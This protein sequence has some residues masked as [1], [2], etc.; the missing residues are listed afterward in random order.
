MDA[1]NINIFIYALWFEN[2]HVHL[3]SGTA[4]RELQGGI[5]VYAVAHLVV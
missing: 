4:E 2:G 1:S 3:A 5:P